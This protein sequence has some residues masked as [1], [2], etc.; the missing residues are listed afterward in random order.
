MHKRFKTKRIIAAGVLNLLFT[1]LPANAAT[2]KIEPIENRKP[3]IEIERNTDDG[4]T[5]YILGNGDELILEVLELPELSGRFTIGPDGKLF[6]PTLKS[7]YAEGLTVNEL[8]NKLLPLYKEYVKD[9]NISIRS[10]GYR[11]VR[12]YVGGEIARPGYYTLSGAFV[13]PVQPRS[14]APTAFSN[15]FSI[16]E[17]INPDP[18]LTLPSGPSRSGLFPTVYDALRMSQGI[19]PYSDLSSIK[20]VRK[21][22]KSKGG[23]RIETS[24]NLFSLITEGDISQNIRLFD[25]DVITV[26]KA[27]SALGE[28]LLKASQSNLNPGILRV[29]VAGRVFKPG[30]VDIPQGSGLNQALTYT[31]GPRLLKGKVEFVRFNPKGEVTRRLFTYSPSAK[32]NTYKNPI[33]MNGDVIRVRNS[34]L[35]ATTEVLREVS[36]P[37]ISAYSLYNLI[38][39]F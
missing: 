15:G 2:Q 21:Q 10:I 20:V 4:N 33:L 5:E 3:S 7:V 1:A 16:D 13:N 36:S 37:I 22:L 30:A 9:P 23:G 12:V 17:P 11:P 19:T 27:E 14:N 8:E 25:G 24:L 38:G 31:G 6:L 26:P 35:S 34:I 18:L 29:F 32:L 39:D 28:Q